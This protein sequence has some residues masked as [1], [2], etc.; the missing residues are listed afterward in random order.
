MIEYASF[1]CPHCKNFHDTVYDKLKANYI[2]PGLPSGRSSQP[3]A[4]TNQ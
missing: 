3:P 1:T 2:D 4:G